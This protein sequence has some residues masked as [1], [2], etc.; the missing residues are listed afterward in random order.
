MYVTNHM[1]VSR[2]APVDDD[3]KLKDVPLMPNVGP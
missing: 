3:D 1:E 2:N